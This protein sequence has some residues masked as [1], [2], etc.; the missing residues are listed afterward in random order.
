MNPNFMKLFFTLLQFTL[1]ALCFSSAIFT[2]WA[3]RN[4][5]LLIRIRNEPLRRI[6]LVGM[7]LLFL[8]VGL[9]LTYA[10]YVQWKSN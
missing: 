10:T 3:H 2:K 7:G 1:S 6:I 9:A 5:R 8:F 4:N